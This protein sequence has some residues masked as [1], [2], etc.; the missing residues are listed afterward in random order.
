MSGDLVNKV[1]QG[2]LNNP[3]YQAGTDARKKFVLETLASR[4]RKAATDMMLA[5]KIK[6]PEFRAE[7]IRQQRGK[8]GL[9]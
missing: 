4:A 3:E 6:D 1:L 9:E 8:K 2:T 5:Q 7:Y